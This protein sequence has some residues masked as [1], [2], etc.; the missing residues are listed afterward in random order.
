MILT[1]EISIYMDDI[2][3]FTETE[4]EHW[5]ILFKVL[6]IAKKHDLFFKLSKCKIMQTK[7]IYLGVQISKGQIGMDPDKVKALAEWEYPKNVKDVQRFLGFGNYY[8]QY[9]KMLSDKAQPLYELTEKGRK[10]EWTDRHKKA[11]DLLRRSYVE[12]PTL[13]IPDYTKL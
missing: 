12:G 3:I 6:Q 4:E 10:W 5:R 2:G 1:D 11:W 13:Q 8:R 9:I 7:V